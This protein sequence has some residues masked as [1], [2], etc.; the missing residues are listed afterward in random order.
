MTEFEYQL[1]IFL[2][3]LLLKGDVVKKSEVITD[4]QAG[5]ANMG[6][7]FHHELLIW[8]FFCYL[9]HLRGNA[10]LLKQPTNVF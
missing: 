2:L 10:H 6:I 3:N 7:T 9:P 1:F 8:N 5:V 4:L